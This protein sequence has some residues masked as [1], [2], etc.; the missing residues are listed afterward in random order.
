MYTLV[1]SLMRSRIENNSEKNSLEKNWFSTSNTEELNALDFF[2]YHSTSIEI[3]F[4]GELH[5]IYFPIHPICRYISKN[6]KIRLMTQANR[7][8]PNE[9]LMVEEYIFH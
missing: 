7:G 4:K 1:M 3:S 6:S 2:D 8:S 9:K 5:R